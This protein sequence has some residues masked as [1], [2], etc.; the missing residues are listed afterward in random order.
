MLRKENR[1]WLKTPGI[2]MIGEVALKFVS[3]ALLPHA[4]LPRLIRKDTPVEIA[5]RQRRVL[6]LALLPP[7]PPPPPPSSSNEQSSALFLFFM[8][9]IVTL[10]TKV[11][12][13]LRKHF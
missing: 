5:R 11:L 9:V 12:V 2:A 7:T 1:A 10:I 4:L 6:S 8:F 13:K 3:T